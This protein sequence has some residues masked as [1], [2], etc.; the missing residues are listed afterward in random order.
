MTVTPTLVALLSVFAVWF[1]ACIWTGYRLRVWL[2][3]VVLA[4]GL[5]LNATWMVLGLNA[6]VLEPHAL[7]AQVSVILYAVGGFGFGWL[8]GRVVLR[9]RESRVDKD[10]A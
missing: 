9:W 2:F 8:A 7:L 5:G 4:V 1:F 6:R 10:D 3:F